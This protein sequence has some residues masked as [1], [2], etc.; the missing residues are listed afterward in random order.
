MKLSAYQKQFQAAYIQN[1]RKY[2]SCPAEVVSL[3]LT[4][5]CQCRCVHC[6]SVALYKQEEEKELSYNEIT[7]LIDEIRRLGVNWI[8]FFGGEPLLVPQL[9][10]YIRHAKEKGL[11]V[12]IDTNGLLLD[13]E[14]VKNLKKAG[15]DLVGVSIDSPFEAVHD[16]LRG[17]K[18]TFKKAIAGIKY[19]KKHN[20]ECQLLTYATKENLKN[21]DL[22][23]IIDLAKSFDIP[24]RILPLVLVGKKMKRKDLALSSQDIALLRNLLEKD[25]V[26]WENEFIDSKEVP[27]F[28]TAMHK[29]FFY[30]S[31]YGNVQPCC[32]F[33]VSFGNVRQERLEQIIKKMWNSDLF[34]YYLDHRRYCCPLEDEAFREKYRILR[35]TKGPFPKKYKHAHSMNNVNEKE[36]EVTS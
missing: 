30:I 22:K 13:E 18:G 16:R 21:N 15:I 17:V 34:T 3:A 6:G 28:C 8:D 20:V 32:Y 2:K 1:I 26:H 27:F 35:G 25:K 19:C 4:Y 31:A 24:V 9:A 10:D 5:Q 11:R 36:V 12:R 29:Y 23:K 7:S 14:M 33:P